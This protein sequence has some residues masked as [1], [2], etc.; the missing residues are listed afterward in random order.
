MKRSLESN[1]DFWRR[2]LW[3]SGIFSLA[4]CAAWA[5][6]A[7]EAEIDHP[8]RLQWNANSGYCGETSFIS[9]GLFFGQY[10][11]QY[12]ARRL[13]SPGVPQS[14]L[15]SQLL[16]GNNDVST[17][18]AMR[19]TAIPWNTARQQSTREF[20]V[21][22]KSQVVAGYPVIIGVFTNKYRFCSE[23]RPNAGDPDYDHIVP[24]LAISSERPLAVNARRCF[25]TDVITFSDNGLWSPSTT[26]P[27]LF[28]YHFD[29]FPRDRR[30]ANGPRKPIYSL[31]S[32]GRNYGI[33]IS[34]VK[35]L[36]GDTIPVRVT[37]SVNSEEPEIVDGS[38]TPPAP[39]PLELTVTVTIPDQNS[40]YRLYR[41]QAFSDVP[42]SHFNANSDN[43]VETW[44]I[45]A[46]QGTTFVVT[47]SIFSN[48]VEVFRAVPVSAP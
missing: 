27:Y 30:Q 25:P 41:Y 20:L 33:A 7:H 21:W 29:Q 11:S 32:D 37:T 34:G 48:A 40:V 43:A 5:G 44:E 6:P 17:A 12:E 45:P 23:L 35:D 46:N 26:P 22:V 15:N 3:V 10:C 9:A 42:V 14:N 19:L 38:N 16:L 1:R 8:P 4:V 36:D 47:K 24:V 39:G 18:V 31:N 28:S 13:A 2:F